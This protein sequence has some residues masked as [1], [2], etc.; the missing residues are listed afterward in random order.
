MRSTHSFDKPQSVIM[1][2]RFLAIAFVTLAA[3]SANAE[4]SVQTLYADATAKEAAVR[5]ALS[6]QSAS[7][8]VLRALRTVVSAY[9]ALVRRYPTS[10]YSDDALWRAARLSRDGFSR[11]GQ[12]QDRDASVRLLKALASAYPSSKF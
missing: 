10:S 11:F 9:E 8:M 7:D 5:E 4:L 12:A 3:A 2:K 1:V 6:D